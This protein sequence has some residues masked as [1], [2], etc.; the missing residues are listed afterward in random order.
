MGEM[1]DYY[2]D[3]AF[4]GYGDDGLEQQEDEG[5]LP[6]PIV[7]GKLLTMT[8]RAAL[9]IVPDQGNEWFPLSQ[10]PELQDKQDALGTEVS[11]HCPRW[12]RARKGLVT[13]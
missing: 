13:P 3:L 9:V 7:R 1:A 4:D 2:L 8:P 11:F 5:D 10:C 6:R 12:L